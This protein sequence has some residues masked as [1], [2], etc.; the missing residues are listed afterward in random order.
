MKKILKTAIH[1]VSISI[2]FLVVFVSNMVEKI[3][4]LIKPDSV[5]NQQ[6]YTLDSGIKTALADLG[7]DGT[8]DGSGDD[9]GGDCDGDSGDSDC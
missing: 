6:D 2:L 4:E 5:K 3:S 7:G 8:G 1:L 9:G